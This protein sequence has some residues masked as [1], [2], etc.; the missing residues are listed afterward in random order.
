MTLMENVPGDYSAWLAGLKQRIQAAQQRAAFSVNR[1]LVLL[2]WQIGRDI[3]ER[4]QA[5]GWGR[6]SLTG[7]PKTCP[8]PSRT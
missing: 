1:E 7:W 5:Q 2:Y 3:R 8:P 6:K 4:Q